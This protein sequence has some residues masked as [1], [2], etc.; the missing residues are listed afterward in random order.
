MLAD[1]VRGVIASEADFQLVGE[2]G[3]T[4]ALARVVS[5][6]GVDVL[7]LGGSLSPAGAMHLLYQAPRLK[8]ITIDSDGHSGAV[9]E[10]RLRRGKLH[11]ISATTLVAAI[12]SAAKKR[13][14]RTTLGEPEA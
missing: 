3:E 14:P 9:H 6:G 13:D 10:F 8:I 1:I 2:V 12:R 4:S 7:V 11:E 5:A